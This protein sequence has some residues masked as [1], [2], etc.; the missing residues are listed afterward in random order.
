MTSTRPFAT[1]GRLVG[2]GLVLHGIALVGRLIGLAGAPVAEPW[3]AALVHGLAVGV[4]LALVA[5]ALA[6]VA[7]RRRD[8][9]LLGVAAVLLLPAIVL[10]F[11]ASLLATLAWLGA[12]RGMP[13]RADLARP[14]RPTALVIPVVGLVAAAALVPA[15][16]QRPMCWTFAEDEDGDRTYELAPELVEGPTYD[17]AEPGLSWSTLTSAGSTESRPAGGDTPDDV[18]R[19][20]D[21]CVSHRAGPLQAAV[22]GG[23][24]LAAVG[25]AYRLAA[26]RPGAADDAPGTSRPA[27]ASADEG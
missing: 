13:H 8:R 21:S 6:I 4:P 12:L 3:Q 9:V 26:V 24:A 15:V 22:A 16:Y 19:V 18:V 5:P 10:T 2:A 23:L 20:G 1:P 14:V 11:G 17:L 27:S 7:W 25:V